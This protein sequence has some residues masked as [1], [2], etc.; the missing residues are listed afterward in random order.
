MNLPY[1]EAAEQNKQVI[2]DAIR[3]H[4]TGDVL[5]IGSG[6]G[7]HAEYFARQMPAVTWQTSDLAPGIAGLEARVRAAGLDNLPPPLELDVLDS[8]P[9]RDFDFVFTANSFH[10]MSEAMVAACFAGVGCCLRPGGIFAV[11]GPFN[12]RGEYTSPSNASFDRMLRQRDPSSGIKDVV[13]LA[14]L[15]SEAGLELLD[16]IEMP[17]NNRTL[18]WQKRTY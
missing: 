11:Y 7:Q 8:W 15:A 2:F 1:A 12:Y 6:S 17:V 4:L 14:E 10:I 13:W 5:E 16:D 18:L 9:R 3:E